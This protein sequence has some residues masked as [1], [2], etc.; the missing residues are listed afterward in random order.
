MLSEGVA[1]VFESFNNNFQKSAIVASMCNEFGIPHFAGHWS[2]ELPEYKRP[3]RKFTRNFFPTSNHFS[4]ALADL[5]VDYDWS[6]FTII[7][8]DD[9]SLMR[10]HDVLQIHDT[11]DSPV[12][13]R[14]LVEGDDFMPMLKE[15]ASFGE[16]RIILDC[17]GDKVLSILKQAI[18]VKM[19]EEYQSYIITSP[20]SHI[21]DFSELQYNR[22]NITTFRMI[23]PNSVDAET[24]VHDWRQGESRRNSEYNILTDKIKV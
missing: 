14:K 24:A 9:Y 12:V 15:I 2:P 17:S 22:A 19:L 6:A 13:V 18:P 23:N 11:E 21:I 7:Y 5:L 1:A 4:R 10:L 20:D 16:T 3:F 8:E